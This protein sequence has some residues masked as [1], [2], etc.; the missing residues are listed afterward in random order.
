[1]WKKVQEHVDTALLGSTSLIVF[2]VFQFLWYV[3][4]P[5]Q[6]VPM[7]VLMAMLIVF[8]ICCVV[9]YAVCKTRTVTVR[10]QLPLIRNFRRVNG[11]IILIVDR[12]DLFSDG[13]F[14]TVYRPGSVR[15]LEIPLAIGRVEITSS[16]EYMQIILVQ[17]MEQQ[18]TDGI[19]RESGRASVWKLVSVKP[20]ISQE[21]IKFLLT[22]MDWNRA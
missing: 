14:V 6:P 19:F 2:L 7:W 11:R 3:F 22:Q 21:H 18:L 5:N 13:A 20:V 4:S 8:Y 12:D 9:L 1:M 16:Q 10:Y 15:D 17:I